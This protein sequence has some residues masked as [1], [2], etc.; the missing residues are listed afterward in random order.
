MTGGG[1]NGSGQHYNNDLDATYELLRMN[2]AVIG[3]LLISAPPL[4][5][6]NDKENRKRFSSILNDY[7]APFCASKRV[8]V[9]SV[10][11]NIN[12]SSSSSSS[13]SSSTKKNNNLRMRLGGKS[14]T[15]KTNI[16]TN[17]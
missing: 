9:S 12:S 13:N 5:I 8:K 16:K 15:K 7:T 4:P 3:N 17:N 11:I 6:N 2:P 14:V 10:N 1:G